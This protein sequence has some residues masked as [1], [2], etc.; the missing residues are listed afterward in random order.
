MAGK[1]K[2]VFSFVSDDEPEIVYC[3]YCEKVPVKSKLGPRV[4]DDDKPLPYDADQWLQCTRN[5]AHIIPLYEV[6]E[7]LSYGPIVDVIDS[8][9]DSG[10]DIR[11]VDKR[12]KKKR[13]KKDDIDPDMAGERGEVNVLYDSSSN[14]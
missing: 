7:E 12:T 14:Y 13:K 3:P 1:R 2:P 6:K 11:S 4:Y 5:G 10:T 9:F 8:P